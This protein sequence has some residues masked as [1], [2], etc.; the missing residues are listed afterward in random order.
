M[1]VTGREPALVIEPKAPLE[2]CFTAFADTDERI[3]FYDTESL[4][5]N[6]EPVSRAPFLGIEHG[7]AARVLDRQ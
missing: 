2:F 5:P 7:D 4:A 1:K 3:V 6:L